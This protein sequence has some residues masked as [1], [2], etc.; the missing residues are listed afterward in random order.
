M[1]N[2][3]FATTALVATAFAGSAYADAHMSVGLSG[4]V[5]A[6]YNDD[7]EGGLFGDF[8][9]DVTGKWEGDG[10]T[11]EVKFGGDADFDETGADGATWD[12]N[13]TFTLT[14]P[15]GEL[16]VGDLD[17]KGASERFYADREGMADD[18]FNDDGNDSISWHGDVGDFGYAISTPVDGDDENWS[19][20]LGGSFGVVS[21]GIGYDNVASGDAT[22]AVSVD[23]DAGVAD[24]G[25]SYISKG[26]DTSFGAVASAEVSAG[27]TLGAFY[28]QNG[29][30]GDEDKYGVLVDYV[31]GPLTVGVDFTA[32]ETSEAEIDVVYDAG[33]ASIQLGYDEGSDGGYIGAVVPLN[34]YV[35]VIAAYA[36]YDEA[37]DY[38][39]KQGT[40]LYVTASF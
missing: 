5:K 10:Y 6:G 36:E 32:G 26:G 25:L 19:I 21:F 9:I 38:E 27:L 12:D 17:D 33:V 16:K 23:F 4:G 11:L 30:A 3:L 15:V 29:G 35:D 13:A 24:I 28:A 39:F 14:T 1:K 20:G 2:V 8:N 34:D 37:G 40:S 22:S 18:V 7:I 31:N